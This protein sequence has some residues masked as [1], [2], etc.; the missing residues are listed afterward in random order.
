VVHR[1]C[2]KRHKLKKGN[3]DRIMPREIDIGQASECFRYISE[4]ERRASPALKEMIVDRSDNAGFLRID[5]DNCIQILVNP[6]T[7]DVCAVVWSWRSSRMR[8]RTGGTTRSRPTLTR[9]CR[10]ALKPSGLGMK[11]ALRERGILL[12]EKILSIPKGIYYEDPA[13]RAIADDE[14]RA[15]PAPHHDERGAPTFTKSAKR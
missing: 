14:H 10:A 4:F 11:G 2:F 6:L 3:L 13:Q 1:A 15:E 5:L 12:S 9:K 8:S 7:V